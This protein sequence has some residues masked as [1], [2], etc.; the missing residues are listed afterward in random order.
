MPRPIVIE[1]FQILA[2]I[3]EDVL[4]TVSNSSQ[5]GNRFFDKAAMGLKT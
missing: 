1:P 4:S 3:M 5:V 2:D